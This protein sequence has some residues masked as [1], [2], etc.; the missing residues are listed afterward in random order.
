MPTLA[1]VGHLIQIAGAHTPTPTHV[2]SGPKSLLVVIINRLRDSTPGRIK[3]IK[4]P[5]LD[6]NRCHFSSMYGCGL[7]PRQ[8]N[9]LKHLP[10]SRGSMLSFK[11]QACLER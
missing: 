4:G 1:N 5:Q 7:A 11:M 10:V 8:R 3:G 2:N 6:R 9:R